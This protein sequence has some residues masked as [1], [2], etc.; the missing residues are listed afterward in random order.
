MKNL[1][2]L[3]IALLSCS[4]LL[5]GLTGLQA[6]Y[7]INAAGGNA[8]GSGG[9]VSFSLGQVAFISQVGSGGSINEGVQQALEI[10]V[11][12][13]VDESLL[14]F[15]ATAFP[16]PTVEQAYLDIPEAMG[17]DLSFSM[18]DIHGRLL[19]AEQIDS[20]L[21]QVKMNHLAPGTY[22]ITL[23]RQGRPVKT[24][25]IIKNN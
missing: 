10:Y 7:S 1:Q 12:T 9:S 14:D 5:L 19:K 15:T 8:T 2:N 25:K 17:R 20:P 11:T 22:F 3:K 21:T 13:A 6:Q 16:N 18:A 23:A 24:F 4:F